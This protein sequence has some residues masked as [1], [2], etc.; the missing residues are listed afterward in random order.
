[1]LF[2]HLYIDNLFS[3]KQASLDLTYARPIQ[4]STIANEHL[5]GRAKFYV[6]KVAILSGAN[7]TGKTSLGTLLNLI[8][9]FVVLQKKCS[10]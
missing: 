4:N 1:M 5:S 8:Q 10:Y 7:A 3:F 6:R 2:T 9:N